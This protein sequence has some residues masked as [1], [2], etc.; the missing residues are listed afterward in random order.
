MPSVITD[1]ASGQRVICDPVHNHIYIDKNKEHLINEL[2]DSREVQ[3]LR[4]IRQLGLSHLTYPGAVHTRFSHC[5]GT[6]HLSKLALKYLLDNAGKKINEEVRLAIL[7]AALLHDIGHGPFSHVLENIT[8]VNHEKWTDKIIES[9]ESEVNKILR[10]HDNNL[11]N[12]IRSILLG[13][14]KKHSLFSTLI[15][16]QLDVDRMDYLLRDSYF[17]GNSFGTFDYRWILHTLHIGEIPLAGRKTQQP[18]WPEKALCAIEDY[19]YARY[20]MYRTVYFHAT[21]RGFEELLVAIL[22]RAKKL[23][24]EDRKILIISDKIKKYLLNPSSISFDEFLFLDD[25]ILQS[26]IRLWEESRD[27]ILCDLCRRLTNRQGLKWVLYKENEDRSIRFGSLEAAHQRIRELIKNKGFDPEYYF[28][29]NVSVNKAYKYYQ[30]EKGIDEQTP[31]NSIFIFDS[32][33]RPVEIT[34]LTGMTHIR[35]IA[36]KRETRKYYYVPKE[37]RQEVRRIFEEISR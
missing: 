35:A 10:S 6:F 34:N 22:K 27:K 26:Q 33:N 4:R 2:L 5:L 14:D 13:T 25:F 8:K 28:I 23:L 31:I 24:E 21:T 20:N 9:G 16:S 1:S 30:F 36:E 29:E 3:R 37:C 32:D 12:L 17:C 11:P 19:I 18:V 15:C 7:A